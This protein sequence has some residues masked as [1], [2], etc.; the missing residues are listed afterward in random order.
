MKV[1]IVGSSRCGTTV[2][3]EALHRHD[4]LSIINE[5]H[6]LPKMFEF[7][8]TRRVPY[9]QLLNLAE[10]TAWDSGKDL[11]SVNL[12][13]SPFESRDELMLALTSR[14]SRLGS[15]SIQE[16]SAVFGHTGGQVLY[17]ASF[18]PRAI[19]LAVDR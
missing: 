6:W 19:R 15:I 17:L 3:R 14:L 11:F 5:T 1:C 9:D 10:R 13:Y 12:A 2:L 4:E 7:Y 16:F 8:G 18:L